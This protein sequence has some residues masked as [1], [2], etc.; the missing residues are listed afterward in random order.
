MSACA[1]PVS[2]RMTDAILDP[3]TGRS[4]KPAGRPTRRAASA[5]GDDLSRR[6]SGHGLDPRGREGETLSVPK[7]VGP[8]TLPSPPPPPAGGEEKKSRPGMQPGGRALGPAG[9]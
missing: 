9:T 4:S 1:V 7:G 8:L 5:D 6:L 2:R 3:V